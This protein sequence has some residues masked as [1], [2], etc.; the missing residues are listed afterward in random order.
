MVIMKLL[1]PIRREYYLL[2]KHVTMEHMNAFLG[3]SLRVCLYT[4]GRIKCLSLI[5][6]MIYH[7]IIIIP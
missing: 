7:I 1:F 2:I 5:Q 3:N 6:N 4:F